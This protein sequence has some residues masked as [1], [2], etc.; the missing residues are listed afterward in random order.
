MTDKMPHYLTV[1]GAIVTLTEYQDKGWRCWDWKC[2]GCGEKS[3]GYTSR[4]G[5]R[6]EANQHAGQ[7]RAM[8]PS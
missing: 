3:I 7:C 6:S 1:G 8:P 4:T 5:A 2:D